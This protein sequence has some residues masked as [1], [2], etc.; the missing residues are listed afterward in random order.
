M[1]CDLSAPDQGLLNPATSEKIIKNDVTSWGTVTHQPLDLLRVNNQVYNE[2]SEIC[3]SRNIFVFGLGDNRSASKKLDIEAMIAFTSEIR[4]GLIS[5]IKSVHIKI[6]DYEHHQNPN[7]CQCRAPKRE[8]SA[9]LLGAAILLVTHFRGL[10]SLKINDSEVNMFDSEFAREHFILHNLLLAVA[11]LGD[12][13]RDPK[14]HL[15]IDA[16]AHL[17]MLDIT[18][19]LTNLQP[20][21]EGI[22][23]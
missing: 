17:P 6:L 12:F 14:L 4:L 16:K 21:I 3:Y 2:A 22:T 9:D 1:G 10:Q 13:I 11:E 8:E 5:L 15:H 7:R 19:A 23:N 18:W 20:M